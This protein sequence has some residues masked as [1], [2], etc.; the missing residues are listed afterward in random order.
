MIL[1]RAFLKRMALA[2]AACAFIDVPW[3]QAHGY[4]RR[5]WD[6]ETWRYSPREAYTFVE[7]DRPRDEQRKPMGRI[8]NIDLAV[9]VTR[10]I[11][12]A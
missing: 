10:G 7:D 8:V 6:G 1:R 4:G 3:S 5:V 12:R 11:T 2:A 9:E